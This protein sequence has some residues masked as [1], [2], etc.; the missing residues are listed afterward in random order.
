M[1]WQLLVSAVPIGAV[2]SVLLL[3][4]KRYGRQDPTS[5][6]PTIPKAQIANTE[7]PATTKDK[8]SH[9]FDEIMKLD[10]HKV[11]EKT[12]SHEEEEEESKKKYIK[13][14]RARA[15]LDL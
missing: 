3:G 15:L 2:A 14:A 4:R 13:F 11:P 7:N 8:I 12:P 6:N 10:Q 5:Q 9:M 1:N